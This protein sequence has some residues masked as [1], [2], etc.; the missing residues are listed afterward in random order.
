MESTKTPASKQPI[1]VL[2]V[3]IA[4]NLRKKKLRRLRWSF[5]RENPNGH[6]GRY[7]DRPL[8]AIPI[9]M[10]TP[11]ATAMA[12]SGRCSVSLEIWLRSASVDEEKPIQICARFLAAKSLAPWDRQHYRGHLDGGHR[13]RSGATFCPRS[14]RRCSP[15]IFNNT[16]FLLLT[17]ISMMQAVIGIL[18]NARTMRRSIDI[19]PGA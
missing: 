6:C 8:A 7:R 19:V 1:L 9:R 4:A 10:P 15:R 12:M 17:L 18:I 13:R 5:E 16:E 11:N 2:L 3:C 14:G